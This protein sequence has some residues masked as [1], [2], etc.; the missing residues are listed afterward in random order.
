MGWFDGKPTQSPAPAPKESKYSVAKVARFGPL[1]LGVTNPRMKVLITQITWGT[2]PYLNTLNGGKPEAADLADAQ[3]T[4]DMLIQTVEGYVKIQN[5]PPTPQSDEL[6]DKGFQAL[7]TFWTKISAT[8]PS[9]L[10]D[11]SAYLALTG[12]LSSGQTQ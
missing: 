2:L 11:T 1:R 10:G 7:H 8:S 5:S 9:S 4:L 3:T 12:Y 6:M